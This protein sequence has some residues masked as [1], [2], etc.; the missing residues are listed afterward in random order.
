MWY[1]IF[2]ANACAPMRKPRRIASVCSDIPT[3]SFTIRPFTTAQSSPSICATSTYS[4]CIRC[5]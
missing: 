3:S 5:A 1:S 4:S 2:A